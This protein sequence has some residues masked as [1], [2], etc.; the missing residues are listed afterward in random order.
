MARTSQSK[1]LKSLQEFSS[2]VETSSDETSVK[3]QESVKN[4]DFNNYLKLLKS[5]GKKTK[6]GVAKMAKEGR[7]SEAAIA[8][9]WELLFEYFCSISGKAL[10]T[11]ELNT[12]AGIIQKLASGENSTKNLIRKIGESN[13]DGTISSDALLEIERRLNLL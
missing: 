11:S 10:E 6:A 8:M 12:L 4:S 5:A 2:E 7:F 13:Q 3:I 9:A 1:I